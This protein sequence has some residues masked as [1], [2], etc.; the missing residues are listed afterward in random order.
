MNLTNYTDVPV[1]LP[2]GMRMFLLVVL[3]VCVVDLVMSFYRLIRHRGPITIQ[4]LFEPML[5]VL[6]RD[7]L[8][9][10]R[11]AKIRRHLHDDDEAE[12]TTD[13]AL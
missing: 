12:P 3:A 4:M 7:T 9:Q 8:F 5:Y 6:I 11:V 13:E 2:H 1:A 10:A